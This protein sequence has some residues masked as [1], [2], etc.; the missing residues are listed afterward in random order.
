MSEGF[1]LWLRSEETMEQVLLKLA[2]SAAAGGWPAA[3]AISVVALACMGAVFAM[4]WFWVSLA[5]AIV[6]N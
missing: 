3:F 6:R 1:G 5:N 2:E 4:C